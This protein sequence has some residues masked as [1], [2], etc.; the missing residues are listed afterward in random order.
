MEFK[1]TSI[2]WNSLSQLNS[3]TAMGHPDM[4]LGAIRDILP[5]SLLRKLEGTSEVPL[6]SL[7]LLCAEIDSVAQQ[8]TTLMEAMQNK[9]L[10]HLYPPLRILRNKVQQALSGQ[11]QRDCLR[12]AQLHLGQLIQRLG[13]N[14]HDGLVR[15]ERT[16][17]LRLCMAEA[18]NPQVFDVLWGSSDHHD[19]ITE[20]ASDSVRFFTGCLLLYVPDRRFDPALESI[21]GQARHN[22]RKAELNGKI[23]ALR[24]FE[25]VFSG[26]TSSFRIQLAEQNLESLGAEPEVLPVVRPQ[27]SELGQLQAEFNNIMSTIVLRSPRPST[28]QLVYEGQSAQVQ[29]IK[30]LRTNIT[31]AVLRLSQSFHASDD[32]TKPLIAMLQGLDI[33]LA[34]ALLAGYGKGL[35]NDDIKY[36][37]SIT[38]FLGGAPH[39]IFNV[40]LSDLQNHSTD[41]IDCRLRFLSCIAV[42]RSV[43]R[44]LEAASVDRVFQAF[45]SL[46]EEWKERLGRDQQQ[47]ATKSSLYRYR[48]SGEDSNEADDQDFYQLFPLYDR[49]SEDGTGRMKGGKIDPKQQAQCLA[50]VQRQ[51]FQNT[52]S[53]P[54]GLLHL[55]RNASR[56]IAGL[57]QGQSNISTSPVPA[58]TLLPALVLSLY[59]VKDRLQ[60]KDAQGNLYNFYTDA[61]VS[62]AQKLIVLIR[63]IQARFGD[64]QE[65]W[66]EHATLSEVLR[67]SSELLSLRH[68]EPIA[69]LLTKTEQL[70]GYIHEWQI[71]ASKQ[72]TAV[73]LY[74][75]LTELLISWRRAELST[76]ARLLD[77]EDRKC[78]DDADSWWFLAYEVIIAAPLSMIR[79][80]EDV[81]VHT[82]HLFSTLAE[83]ITT[84]SMGQYAH[85]LGMI[86]CFRS[87]IDILM[88]DVPSMSVVYNA[89]TN[90]LS[91]Y[92]LFQHSVQDVV[93]K[94]RQSLEKDMKEI[95]L[96][97]SWNDTN[98]NALRESAK[99]SH[100]K[101]LKIVRKYRTLLAQ[102]AETTT[103]QEIPDIYD[104]LAPSM[105]SVIPADSVDPR[106][107]RICQQG[108]LTW[109]TKQ[110][111]FTKPMSTATRML[112][113]SLPIFVA[114]DPAPYLD[115]FG[116]ELIYSIK[117]LQ[118]ETPSN[119]SN[120]KGEVFKHL[121]A[122]KRKLFADTLKSLRQMGFRSNMSAHA[123]AKQAS[124]AAILTH[125]PGFGDRWYRNDSKT[126][127][128]YFNKLLGLM[129]QARERARNHSEDLTHDEISRSLG[130]MES[131]V[132]VIL[133]QRTVLASTVDDLDASEESIKI[134]KRLSPDSRTLKHQNPSK[135]TSLDEIRY[136]LRWLPSILEI[137]S[138]IIERHGKLG[139]IDLSTILEGL[140]QWKD[141]VVASVMAVDELPEASLGSLNLTSSRYDQKLAEAETLIQ[142]LKANLR[143]LMK[144]HP[145][146]G[147]V[148]KQIELWTSLKNGA[149]K[150]HLNGA[151]PLE[152]EAFDDA[153]SGVVDAVLVAIQRLR[154]SIAAIPTSDDVAWLFHI[155]NLQGL[156]LKTLQVAAVIKSL[157][158]AISMMRQ[159]DSVEE[160][161]LSVAGAICAMALPIV[162]QYHN[163]H[164]AALHRH[165]LFHGSLCKLSS[166]LAHSFIQIALDGFCGPAE[167]SAADSAKTEKLEGGT[168]LGE[169]EGAEDISKDIQDDEDLSEL[170]QG[171]DKDNKREEIQ[172]QEDAVDMD[173]DE[174][175][176]EVE[177]GSDKAEE[178]EIASDREDN[179][180]DI[181]EE[182]GSVDNLDPTAVD[183][184]L[185]NGEAEETDK[186]KE[187]SKSKGETNKD[188]QMAA[189]SGAQQANN[190][191]EEKEENNEVND[192]G[193]EEGDE[194]AKEETEK[195]DPHTQ[196]GRNLDLPEEMDLDNTDGSEANSESGESDL[197]GMSDIEE[198]ET[199]EDMGDQQDD[200]TLGGEL[201]ESAEAQSAQP[202]DHEEA[203]GEANDAKAA[204]SPV[205]TEPSDDGEEEDNQGLLHD[206]S[207]DDAV[208]QDNAAPSDVRG[209]D[210]DMDPD[211]DDE[212]ASTSQA[213]ASKG[214]KGS[215]PDQVDAEAAADNGQQGPSKDRSEGDQSQDS[216]Q[217]A[218]NASQ[219][220]K[221]LGDALE[222]W[223]RQTSQIR[224]AAEQEEKA[225]PEARDV[226]MADQEFEHLRDDE[227]E[228]DTQALGAA[229]DEQ[230]R[231]LNEDAMDS[232]MREETRD[233][234]PDQ[235]NEE[236]GTDNDESMDDVLNPIM[237]DSRDPPE[238]PRPS[239]LVNNNLDRSKN[240]PQANLA[241][242]QN[243]GDI[244]DLDNDFSITNLRSADGTPARSGEEARRLWS[245]YENLTRDLSLSLTE[246]LRLTLAPTLATKMRGDFRTGKRLNI[247]RIIPYIASQ[248]KRDKIWMR[249]SI[250]SK[251]NYQIMLAIDDSKS[252]GESGSGQLA[253]ETLALVAKSLSMLEVGQ[254]S[255]VGFGNEVHV[256]HAFDKPF[257]SEAGAQIFQHFAFQQTKTNVRKLV[258]ES[259]GLFREARRKNFNAG[260]DLWQLEL[261]VSDGV[262]EDH[263]I[264]R[265][266][267]RQAQEEHIM[268]VFV[269]VDALLKGESIMDMKQAIFSES[270]EIQMKRYLDGFPFPYYLVV[271]DV[272]ELP[273]VLSQALRQWFAEVVESG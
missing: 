271:G 68:T 179:D 47:S 88:K 100:H 48:G 224:E 135:A 35:G 162:E 74:D 64:L 250:P 213:Q 113:M 199:L 174:M 197:D 144:S 119:M 222:E 153:M 121:K 97:A 70:H 112:R 262:C 243:D 116:A 187:G 178:D 139:G 56:D 24:E 21:V 156:S 164:K 186:E 107:L 252:M 123:L 105:S 126:A 138:S 55:L 141:R 79:A 206:R 208:D 165:L 71:V 200:D 266:L 256:A 189:D 103:G 205:D 92:T 191:E 248:Y 193:A 36:L 32:V 273:G 264:I 272:R 173:Y 29:E 128:F 216:Q 65:A 43:N 91:Y 73:T 51:I 211:Q 167:D 255:I 54:E 7:E 270:G 37:C 82:E 245:H 46:Y 72:Y 143:D 231:A 148:F 217:D 183:E 84:T 168:G 2:A 169:G 4:E 59:E 212:Q 177:E 40:T 249:R 239:I 104:L 124:T 22:K 89:I 233:F 158:A 195:M 38:P 61:N 136:I 218:S 226:N 13:G 77:M 94:G 172:D 214:T 1:D 31:Q 120:K 268:I 152:L 154:D 170:A 98:I 3:M 149:S 90:F 20:A 198:K 87:H 44:E 204:N 194:I 99:R 184:K 225:Q 81:H 228:G 86:A 251:R 145:G 18:T 41:Q 117:A 34:L 180:N 150:E 219:A 5:M 160:G 209:F 241:D 85:R 14:T 127:E 257:S 15:D 246:Q 223:H 253:F 203:E 242:L 244:E 30:L 265:R 129:P 66:P 125:N 53:A 254:I 102:S 259:I 63:K 131:M 106:A 115:S 260:T 146:L 227:V 45:H 52:Q 238:Q 221:K 185:W 235:A 151:H 130:Y 236:A 171:Q 39:H 26:Q 101:L 95:L 229:T 50:Q 122:R 27:V 201:K 33:G 134:M 263:E 28:L 11:D 155:D 140:E 96:L 220:F 230:A 166:R 192:E 62:Q 210:E 176:G 240:P 75:Q 80:G 188:E 202:D 93:H 159:L 109:Q 16:Q 267:V 147:Y 108:L 237:K 110:E 269:I 49:P 157:D 142:D 10:D 258:A 132:A 247:K 207:D 67:T 190:A 76:W 78:F 181:D 114:F 69:K 261:I 234:P 9:P 60:G 215:A 57:W 133:R 17:H 25:A 232:E 58:A 12:D 163:I 19:D 182:T 111:R 42:A 8:L 137:G 83:F 196:E 175:E 118:K 161:N 23:Q 6:Q